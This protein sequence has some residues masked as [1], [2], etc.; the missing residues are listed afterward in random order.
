MACYIAEHACQLVYAAMFDMYAALL[1]PV[2][3]ALFF[4]MYAA[5]FSVYAALRKF[6][7]VDPCLGSLMQHSCAQWYRPEVL[8]YFCQ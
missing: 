7:A 6:S 8:P 4:N 2:Y 1:L 5:L 3:A